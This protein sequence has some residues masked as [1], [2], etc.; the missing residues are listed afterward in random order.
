MSTRQAITDQY[1]IWLNRT[2]D[3]SGL[4]HYVNLVDYENWTIEM[5]SNDMNHSDEFYRT[6]GAQVDTWYRDIL[7]REPDDEGRAHYID[8]IKRVGFEQLDPIQ[9]TFY[10]SDEYK[11]NQEEDE[12]EAAD[13]NKIIIHGKTYKLP[14]EGAGGEGNEMFGDADY[15]FLLEK[16]GKGADG[17]DTGYRDRAAL[18]DVREHIIYWMDNGKGKDFL[19]ENNKPGAATDT[20]SGKGLYD[21]IKQSGT[22]SADPPGSGTQFSGFADHSKHFDSASYGI[23]DVL[24]ARAGGHSEFNIYSHMRRN[25]NLWDKAGEN[26]DSHRDLYNNIRGDLIRIGNTQGNL[27]GNEETVDGVHYRLSLIHI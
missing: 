3:E 27:A 12:Q 7:G 6:A 20:P 16:A 22:S 17:N 19:S 24:A 21:R 23:A 11:N 10:D 2:P 8:Q 13:D 18:E 25:K 4:N 26:Y 14:I 15:Y 5:V 1:R 9:Q